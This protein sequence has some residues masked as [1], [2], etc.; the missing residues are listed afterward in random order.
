ML[1]I[2][3]GLG[4]LQSEPFFLME[5]FHIKLKKMHI[6]PHIAENVYRPKFKFN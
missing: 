6:N 5:D 3:N 2:L 4:L 1:K